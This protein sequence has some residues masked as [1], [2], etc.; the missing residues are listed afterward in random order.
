MK[1]AFLSKFGDWLVMKN[2]MCHG[3]SHDSIMVKSDNRE[4]FNSSSMPLILFYKNPPDISQFGW[5]PPIPRRHHVLLDTSKS[6][7]LYPIEL[8]TSSFHFN[9][10]FTFSI[11]DN[12]QKYIFFSRPKGPFPLPSFCYENWPK[13]GCTIKYFM[14]SITG[15][16]ASRKRHNNPKIGK[17]PSKCVLQERQKLLHIGRGAFFMKRQSAL[18]ISTE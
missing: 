5:K 11:E 7:W 10:F 6:A 9:P 14:E 13:K 8:G 17:N 3:Q 15:N 18:D 4:N 12:I 1:R 16:R 2:K